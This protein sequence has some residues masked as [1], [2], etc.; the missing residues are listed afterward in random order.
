MRSILF[1]SLLLAISLSLY[2]HCLV[3]FGHFIDL[4]TNF[5]AGSWLLLLIRL[6]LLIL[7]LALTFQEIN[8]SLLVVLIHLL[9]LFWANEQAKLRKLSEFLLLLLLVFDLNG[10]RSL[11]ALLLLLLWLGWLLLLLL[12]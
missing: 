1:H 9:E 5:W 12:L 4:S 6:L 11:N 3:D 7:V 10:L 8:E 2:S